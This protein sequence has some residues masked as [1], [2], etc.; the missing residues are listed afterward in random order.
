MQDRRRVRRGLRPAFSLLEITLVVL[1]IG[2]LAGAAAIAIPGQ[3]K[4]ARINT[5]KADLNLFKSQINTYM[6][7]HQGSAPA[8]LTLLIGDYLDENDFVDPWGTPVYY[9][10]TPGTARPF[11]LISAGPDKQ[12]GTEDDLDVWT[13]NQD[14]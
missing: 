7:E 14:P 4:R 13:M 3:L 10:P 6:G 8:S 1:I 9:K 2:I 5:V 11:L 12:L